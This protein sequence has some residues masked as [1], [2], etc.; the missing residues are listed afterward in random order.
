[1]NRS[2]IDS[3]VQ[4][5]INGK[6]LFVIPRSS[7][8]FFSENN[9]ATLLINNYHFEKIAIKKKWPRTIE[10]K[11]EEKA[12]ACAWQE[13]GKTYY[14]DDSGYLLEEILAENIDRTQYPLIVNNSGNKTKA[15]VTQIDLNSLHFIFNIF[16]IAKDSPL[17]FEIDYFLIDDESE[18]VKLVPKAG[19]I[20]KFTTR[21]AVEEQMERLII[22]RHEKLEDDFIN[23][24]YIDLRY[25]DKIYFQ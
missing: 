22:I 19:P 12:F 4:E 1:M 8:L 24:Q 15:K 16:E 11:L 13:D 10:I 2:E 14:A 25:G 9:L 21:A 3:L 23:K 7:S 20:I 6:L 5:K 17:G 18:T